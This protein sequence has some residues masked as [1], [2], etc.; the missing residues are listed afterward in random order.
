MK[1]SLALRGSTSDPL[2]FDMSV[3]T[4][5]RGNWVSSLYEM[6][7]ACSAMEAYNTGANPIMISDGTEECYTIT[8]DLDPNTGDLI[9]DFGD[10]GETGPIPYDAT[11]ITIQSEIA[12]VLGQ[13]NFVIYG[14][15]T[16][17]FELCIGG[18][19]TTVTLS[20]GA[21]T[22]LANGVTP[23]VVTITKVEDYLAPTFKYIV[24]NS[25]QGDI[26]PI[27]IKRGSDL[28]LKSMTTDVSSGVVCIN[29]FG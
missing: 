8:F 1:G 10:L 12:G 27:N 21:G 15:F 11:N 3:T 20:N 2:Y 13:G 28:Y 19:L 22:N 14:S 24:A 16:D 23:V 6:P 9:L 4:V 5:T 17:N 7:R 25:S 18:T 29:F 26:V